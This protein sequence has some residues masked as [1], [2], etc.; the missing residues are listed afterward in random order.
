MLNIRLRRGLIAV[1]TTMALVVAACGGDDDSSE[2]TTGGNGTGGDPIESLDDYT[3]SGRLVVW[4]HESP[5]YNTL[6]DEFIADYTAEYPDVEIET[7]A[8]PY[9]DFETKSLVSTS[10]GDG[11]DLVKLPGWSLPDWA[12]KG[13]LLPLE[14]ELFGYEDA[15]DVEA[16]YAPGVLESVSYEDQVFA[17]PI[18]YQ[19]LMLFYNKTHFEEAG[20]DPEAPPRTWEEVI[21]IGEQLTIRNGDRVERAGWSWWYNTPIWVWLELETLA[22]QMG[23][24][25]LTENASE[26]ALTGEIG[27]QAVDYYLGLSNEHRIASREIVATSVLD[28]FSEGTVSMMVSGSFSGPSFSARTDGALS[29]EEGTL[30]V[31]PMPVFEDAVA[32]VTT[33]YAWGWGVTNNASDPRLAAHFAQFLTQGERADRS[34]AEA[35]IAVPYRGF[36]E[37]EAASSSPA[38]EILAAQVANS[39]YGPRSPQFVAMMTELTQ[40]LEAGATGQKSAAQVAEDFDSAMRRVLR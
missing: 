3:P 9:A 39:V 24:S 34:F 23:G 35:G 18:D 8:I 22:Q 25:T 15:A 16:A 17:L 29:F 38:N 36:A 10:A 1:L 14:P 2:A 19:N 5:A 13:L 12:D 32:E 37:S 7:L 11:P 33:A 26:G 21:E 6:F 27:Q 40:Q 28:S 4:L 31:A 20:L 30:G